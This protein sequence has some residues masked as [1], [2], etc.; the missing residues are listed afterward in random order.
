VT[1]P[2][3]ALPRDCTIFL[4]FLV[5]YAGGAL[6]VYLDGEPRPRFY[7]EG[8]PAQIGVELA[9]R[10]ELLDHVRSLQVE[11]GLP[12]T[13]RHNQGAAFST[14]LWAWAESKD[15]AWRATSGAIKPP[16]MVLKMGSSARR[17]L[18]WGLREPL[19]YVSIEPANK[20]LAYAI[21]A[22]QKYATLEKLRIPL[23]GTF[24]RVGR[25]RPAPVVV[26]RMDDDAFYTREQLVGRLKDPPP[27]YM[28]R[29]RA[30][31]VKSR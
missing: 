15:S 9:R 19:V 16:T 28:D 30:G 25:K 18:L 13:K 10:A 17:L 29:L 23:P 22:P 11:I 4:A 14:V 1:P 2:V 7:V 21:R 3:D 5:A 12:E 24:L 26:T 27:P 8:S 6:P 20:R 31:E